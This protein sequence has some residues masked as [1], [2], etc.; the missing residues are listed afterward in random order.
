MRG[1]LRQGEGG[2]LPPLHHAHG[3][4]LLLAEQGHHHQRQVG[5]QRGSDVVTSVRPK[6]HFPYSGGRWNIPT[7]ENCGIFIPNQ[8]KVE[9]SD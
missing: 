6:Q 5:L 2:R 3:Q 1:R 4:G 9:Y 8:N 7:Y